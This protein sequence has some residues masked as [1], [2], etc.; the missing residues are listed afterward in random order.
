MV[1]TT[2]VALSR[3]RQSA[4]RLDCDFC[5]SRHRR[6][7]SRMAGSAPSTDSGSNIVAAVGAAE[8]RR[9][10]RTT[11]GDRGYCEE[12]PATAPTAPRHD[13]A[14]RRAASTAAPRAATPRRLRPAPSGICNCDSDGGGGTQLQ[15]QLRRVHL[16]RRRVRLYT[17]GRLQDPYTAT[18]A[19][20]RTRRRGAPLPPLLPLPPLPPPLPPPPPRHRPVLLR[21]DVGLVRR[22]AMIQS[23]RVPRGGRSA[24]PGLLDLRDENLVVN[25]V[26]A[27]LRLPPGLVLALPLPGDK[28]PDVVELRTR[29]A[30]HLCV[31]QAGCAAGRATAAPAAAAAAAAAATAAATG[32]ATGP[33]LLRGDV[34][35]VRR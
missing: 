24:W 13:A 23:G 32:R 15:R 26:P 6:C 12:C 19:R 18:A 20:R 27:G 17:Y 35:L 25:R 11:C 16:R 10:N 8:R 7:A 14:R 4:T 1:P 5:V 28:Q 21:G 2:L 31:R 9:H 34:G 30:V 29:R 22:W 3:S 33:V